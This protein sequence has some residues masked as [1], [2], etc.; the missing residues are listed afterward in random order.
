MYVH[1]KKWLTLLFSPVS[2]FTKKFVLLVLL[3]SLFFRIKKVEIKLSTAFACT[4]STKTEK[5]EMGFSVYFTFKNSK[6][7]LIS[8]NDRKSELGRKKE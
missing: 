5:L 6:K 1:T 4:L 3:S 7:N 8:F 2:S